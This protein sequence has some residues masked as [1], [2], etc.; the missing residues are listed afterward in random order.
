MKRFYRCFGRGDKL[1]VWD[2]RKVVL[3]TVFLGLLVRIVIAL[4]MGPWRGS[5][6]D[7]Y[8]TF[9][10]NLLAGEG[11]SNMVHY[12]D[13]FF[14][15]IYP[16]FVSFWYLIFGPSPMLVCLIQGVLGCATAIFVYL[17]GKQLFDRNVGYISLITVLFYPYT[18]FLDTALT[19]MSLFTFFLVISIYFLLKVKE[20]PD[21]A[22]IIPAGFS[23]GLAT[24]TRG[25]ILLFL[26]FVAIWLLLMLDF[27][28]AVRTYILIM[29]FVLLSITPWTVRN[30]IVS[31]AFVPITVASKSALWIGNNASL[32]NILLAGKSVDMLETPYPMNN[33]A[34]NVA[35]ESSK[36]Y[37]NEAMTFIRKNPFEVIKLAA[38][39]F[40]I[41]WS[42]DY[43]PRI[44][45]DPNNKEG[46]LLP[47]LKLRS[48]VYAWSYRPVLILGII[49]MIFSFR[50][51]KQTLLLFFLF[52]SFTLA[53]VIT[54]GFPRYRLPLDSFLAIF[55]A[56]GI[57]S[58]MVLARS[59]LQDWQCL[60]SPDGA[61]P[62]ME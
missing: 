2:E 36:K 46:R 54:F 49:G 41:F 53:H 26:P 24:L 23:L 27:S 29:L 19:D 3:L 58:I 20:K 10:R 45:G 32:K 51:W 14:Q 13:I 39:K 21:L 47:G 7:V 6:H 17:I 12:P 40:T 18:T 52:F 30:Y 57:V 5:S 60:R 50:K 59:K 8:D 61:K 34:P 56:Y 42:W 37:Y 35:V 55:A 4:K 48:I 62:H 25:T 9:A 11:F 22:H 28:R 33:V 43:F 38:I 15:P 44:V 31:D 16:L 1:L